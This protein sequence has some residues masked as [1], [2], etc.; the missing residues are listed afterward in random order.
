M[1]FCSVMAANEK[2]LYGPGEGIMVEGALS[3]VKNQ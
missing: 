2:F 3:E 1:G